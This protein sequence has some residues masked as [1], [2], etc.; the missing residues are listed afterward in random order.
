MIPQRATKADHSRRHEWADLLKLVG[1][2]LADR[3]LVKQRAVQPMAGRWHQLTSELPKEKA[4]A[5]KAIFGQAFGAS[6]FDSAPMQQIVRPQMKRA[7]EGAVASMLDYSARKETERHTSD[8]V[9]I[10]AR[11]K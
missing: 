2:P 7:Q 5:A 4:G 3:V 8:D 9:A 11:E 6:P 1:H 10:I